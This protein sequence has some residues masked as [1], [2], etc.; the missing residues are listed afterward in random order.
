MST[1]LNLIVYDI[2]LDT[3]VSDQVASGLSSSPFLDQNV[4]PPE[5]KTN[6]L[7]HPFKAMYPRLEDLNFLLTYFEVFR[8]NIIKGLTT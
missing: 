3:V 2:S 1:F 6:L 5:A 7:M 4:S 8:L